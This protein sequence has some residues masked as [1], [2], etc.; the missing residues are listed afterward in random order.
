M[1]GDIEIHVKFSNTK[2]VQPQEADS[3]LIGGSDFKFVL[4]WRKIKGKEDSYSIKKIMLNGKRAEF[5]EINE[6]LVIK[7]RSK[8]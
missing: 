1:K 4:D 8:W 6:H 5:E 2:I 7:K 3:E